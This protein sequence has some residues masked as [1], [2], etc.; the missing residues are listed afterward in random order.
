[1]KFALNHIP[2]I[3]LCTFAVLQG[4]GKRASVI[5]PKVMSDIYFDMFV[6]DQWLRDHYDIKGKADS[7]LVYEPIFNKY[8]YTTADYDN[9]VTYY[10]ERP[11]KYLKIAEKTVARFDEELD[12]LG[13]RNVAKGGD[14]MKKLKLSRDY[15]NDFTK[16]SVRWSF[17]IMKDKVD[18]IFIEHKW[19]I[20]QE[21]T[22][23]LQ[24]MSST[25]Q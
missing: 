12:A 21:N 17:G 16:D 8:G 7:M 24:M 3:L 20:S 6:T 15:K 13:K 5:P 14:G 4:C 23:T 10:L 19:I 1:M 22:D 18:S 11:E 9:S 25:E 2:L